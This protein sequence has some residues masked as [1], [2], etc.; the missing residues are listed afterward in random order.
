VL[1]GLYMGY[2]FVMSII[3]PNWVPALPL[4]GADAGLMA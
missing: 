1:T 3:R 4:G 2:V